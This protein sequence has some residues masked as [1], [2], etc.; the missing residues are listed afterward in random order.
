[1][2]ND[3]R[4]EIY[5]QRIKVGRKLSILYKINARETSWDELHVNESVGTVRQFVK[6]DGCKMSP[7]ILIHVVSVSYYPCIV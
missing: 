4:Y 2:S 1:M 5:L 7:R 6:C 3:W